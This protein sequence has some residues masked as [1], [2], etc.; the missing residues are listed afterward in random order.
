M[1]N[2][3]TPPVFTDGWDGDR[4][5]HSFLA[6]SKGACKYVTKLVGTLKCYQQ[7][8]NGIAKSAPM[9]G[10]KQIPARCVPLWHV[11]VDMDLFIF[12]NKM[13]IKWAFVVHNSVLYCS[14]ECGWGM[15]THAENN[16]KCIMALCFYNDSW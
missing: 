9:L 12:V 4:P 14:N 11:I 10:L 7:M 2:K 16:M 5:G 6:F 1:W 8:G 13:S 3:P 15:T